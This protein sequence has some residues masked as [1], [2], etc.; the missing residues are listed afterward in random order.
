[1][2]TTT[3]TVQLQS[4]LEERASVNDEMRTLLEEAGTG[5]LS[6]ASQEQFNEREKVFNDLNKRK[7][8]LEGQ[9]T[10][11]RELAG[12]NGSFSPFETSDTDGAATR[13]QRAYEGDWTQF[14]RH[15]KSEISN[16]ARVTLRDHNAGRETRE[17][18]VGTPSAGGYFA[19]AS[20]EKKFLEGLQVYSAIRKTRI[21]VL[22]T[23]TGNPINWPTVDTR[24]AAVLVTELQEVP[25]ADDVIG[26]TQLGAYAVGRLV[27]A[28]K[29]L[30]QDSV[31][32]ID[33]FVRNSL[34]FSI[35]KAENYFF[36]RGTGVNQPQGMVTGA[37]AVAA[38][39][40]AAISFDDLVN[41]VYGLEEPYAA[42]AEMMIR[43]GTLGQMRKIKD[44]NG[45]YVWSPSVQVGQ[46]DVILG[47]PVYS[48]PDLDLPAAN[49]TSALVG[50]F[51]LGGIIRQ[52]NGVEVQTLFERF[53]TQRAIGYLGDH[54]VDSRVV[55]PGAFRKLV[56]PAI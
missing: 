13:A 42:N 23:G 15:G 48:S 30:R 3:L 18:V 45:Q 32:D 39:A 53:A 12:G 51:F 25:A 47:I 50:D 34:E 6:E 55:D 19:P 20:W 46:P 38:T 29:E 7:D 35:G 37:T 17:M 40:A 9:L 28:S 36:T 54:R 10:R 22:N 24:G 8:L 14:L 41:L 31:V 5:S 1:M 16:D 56:H 11:E 27:K 2:D 4:V 49:A 26:T 21:Q 33:T 52:V 43:R 44:A